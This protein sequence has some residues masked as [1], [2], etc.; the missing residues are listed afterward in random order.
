MEVRLK[1]EFWIQALIR[2]CA[3]E[4]IPAYVVRRGDENAGVVLVKVNCLDGRASVYF[5]ARGAEGERIW[6]AYNVD[7]GKLLPECDADAFIKRQL[8]FD[9]DVWVIEIEDR[10]GR[11][12]LLEPV[13]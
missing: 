4:G 1:T 12:F 3:I 13:E 5:Q 9:P 11:H 8:D 6:L 2:R 10:Q 7:K